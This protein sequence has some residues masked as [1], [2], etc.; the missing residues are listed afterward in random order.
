MK[1]SLFP[2]KNRLTDDE[3]K[4]AAQAAAAAGLTLDQWL[5]RALKAAIYAPVVGSLTPEKVA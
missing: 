5:E 4:I 3:M 1:T 2:A